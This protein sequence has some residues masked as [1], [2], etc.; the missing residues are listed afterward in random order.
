MDEPS[1]APVGKGC[2]TWEMPII[3]RVFRREFGLLP[4]II[5]AVQPGDLVRAKKVG[6]HAR[7]LLT[8]LHHHHSIEDELLWPAL[9][10]RVTFE[11]PLVERMEAQ[12]ASV[13]SLIYQAQVLIPKW[14]KTG[15]LLTGRDLAEV[16]EH[17]ATELNAHLADEE[18]HILP[19][20]EQHITADEWQR[21]GD[22]GMASIPRNRLLVQLGHILEDTNPEERARFL[23]KVPLPGRIAY[24]LIGERKFR[25]ETADLR[26]GIT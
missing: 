21:L 3:H 23:G 16:L 18:E 12:H 1:G 11:K 6:N 24:R 9:N 25:A 7:E 4:K 5:R 2:D 8:A 13:G 10:E 26:A 19:V 20:V 17:L 15:D 14:S 22:R